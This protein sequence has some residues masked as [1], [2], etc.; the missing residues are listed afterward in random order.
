V[1]EL[2]GKM[3]QIAAPGFT[4]RAFGEESRRIVGHWGV[5]RFA[6][7]LREAVQTAQTVGPVRTDAAARALVFLLNRR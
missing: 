3:A 6:E 2:A 7:G 4:R 5:S 1:D